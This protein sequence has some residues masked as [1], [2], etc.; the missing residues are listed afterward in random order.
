M[1]TLSPEG[2]KRNEFGGVGRGFSFPT[3]AFAVE[4]EYAE[5]EHEDGSW[6][7][8]PLLDARTAAGPGAPVTSPEIAAIGERAYSVFGDLNIGEA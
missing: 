1:N 2:L 5:V 3:D 8:H 6:S 7:A 4:K